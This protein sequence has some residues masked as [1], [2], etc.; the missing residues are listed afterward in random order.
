MQR[1][2][3]VTF[4]GFDAAVCRAGRVGARIP[5]VLG[6]GLVVAIGVDGQAGGVRNESPVER[7]AKP[8]LHINAAP[9]GPTYYGPAQIRHA[10][11]LD[12]IPADGT[13]QT[14][15]IV[16]AYGSPFMQQDLNLFCWYF[17]LPWTTVAVYYPQ[18]QPGL[19]EG[20]AGETA[21]DVEWAH[22]IAP[23]ARLVL[24]V[25][26]TDSL[27]DLL[28][29]VDY[30][31]DV[32]GANVVSMSW[33]FSE[34]SGEVLLDSHFEKAGVTFVTSSGDSG[35]DVQWPAA[36]PYVLSVGGT[37]LYLDGNGNYSSETGWD[38]SGGGI[39]AYEGLPFYQTGW[40]AAT[41][42]GVPDVSYV[43]DPNT[44]VEVVFEGFLYIFGGTSVG[45]PQ[46]AGVMA[47]T[48]SLSRSRGVDSLNQAVYAV[49]SL[50]NSFT[51]DSTY[52][53]DITSGSNGP[54]ADDF[55]APGYDLV[56]GLGSPVG[57]NLVPALTTLSPVPPARLLNVKTALSGY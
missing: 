9:G 18:G 1:S 22:T 5:L 21:L 7:H 29:A 45:A 41:G 52:F 36:S 3:C 39:S 19:D 56:T 14:I 8:P 27:K 26:Q 31:V 54:D 50:H 47:L 13:G 55:A 11:G 23:G 33:G 38:G 12:S 16:D 51:I 53:Y 17:G 4:C 32:V 43:G 37:S 40:L 34:F 28:G 30:A 48:K 49:A 57:Q 44:G 24:V 25:A 35:E 15:A 6:F 46:W 42:R 10:Y 20:W 2:L